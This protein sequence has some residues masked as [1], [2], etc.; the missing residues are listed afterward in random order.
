[1]VNGDTKIV[2]GFAE[3]RDPAKRF[4][5]AAAC[6][7]AEI[8]VHTFPDGESLVRLPD[9]LPPDVIVYCSFNDPNR[10]LIEVE[11]AAAT[12]M[13]LGAERLTLVAPYLCYL[14][15][16]KAF[17]AG[18][19]VSQKVIGEFLARRFDA[20]VTVDPHLHRTH[21]LE[22]AVPVRRAVVVSATPLMTA[23]LN[24]RVAKPLIV[25]PD[26]ESAQWV[27]GIA[28]PGGFEHCV[29]RKERLGDDAV[30][31]DLPDREFAGADI[32]LVD[33]VVSTGETLAE[34]ARQL[35]ARGAASISVLVSHALF[36]SGAEARLAAAGVGDICSADSIPHTSNQLHL[37][38]LLADALGGP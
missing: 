15:Q 33:D 6:D 31:I 19:A 5:A 17:H 3:F 36:T 21:R 1:M 18:E 25:G 26:E 2:L 12:A 30:H 16:D 8:V 11:L 35:S 34:A 4:A 27:E 32:V 9:E 23:W 7:Y 10:R 28:G 38:R 29:A 13:T 20:L 37:A 24:D 22:Q 14:R